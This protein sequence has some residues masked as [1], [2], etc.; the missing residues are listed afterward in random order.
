MNDTPRGPRPSIYTV[1]KVL[2]CR[3]HHLNVS[4]G[5]TPAIDSW[6]QSWLSSEREVAYTAAKRAGGLL[7]KWTEQE[8]AAHLDASVNQEP[9]TP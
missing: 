5:W 1:L 7:V 4:G 8:W 2:G 9:A 3:I 6:T